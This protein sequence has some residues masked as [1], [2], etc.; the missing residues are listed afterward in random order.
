MK[1]TAAAPSNLEI[2]MDKMNL[3][4]KIAAFFWFAK[5]WSPLRIEWNSP[6]TIW[7]MS[8]TYAKRKKAC[9][10]GKMIFC[11]VAGSDGTAKRGE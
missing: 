10:V 9:R 1:N 11:R 5:R 4:Y 2:G 7:K 6:K 3:F 8:K